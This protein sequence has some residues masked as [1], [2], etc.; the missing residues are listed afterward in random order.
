M[1]SY[2]QVSSV[3]NSTETLGGKKKATKPK[4]Y[5]NKYIGTLITW[6]YLLIHNK[7]KARQAQCFLLLHWIKADGKFQYLRTNDCPLESTV[8]LKCYI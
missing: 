5:F 3:R 8:V 2:E 6:Q 7:A 1:N 4:K